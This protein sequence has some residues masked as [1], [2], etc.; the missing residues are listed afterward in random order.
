MALQYNLS[1]V[2]EISEN[3]IDFALQIVNLFL[4]EVPAEIKSIKVGIEEKDFSRA[5]A[6][7]QNKTVIGFI[8]NGFSI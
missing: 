3:D 5:Y 2:Y 8:G 7:A 1:K 6:A 4:L